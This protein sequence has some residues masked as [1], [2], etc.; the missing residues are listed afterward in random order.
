MATTPNPTVG[1]ASNG[2]LDRPSKG[3]LVALL[4]LGLILRAWLCFHDDGIYWPDEIYQSLE[5][6][7]RLVFGYGLIP[8]EFAEGA[9]NWAFPGLVAAILKVAALVGGD[10]PRHYLIAIRLVFS[11]IGMVTAWGTYRLARSCGAR[12]IGAALGAMFFALAP[13][14]IYFAPRALS[15]TAS[16]AAVVFG[17]A[18]VLRP[19]ARRRDVLVGVSLL[20]FSAL[21]RLQ[22]GI[23]C[24]GILGLLI[25]RRRWRHAAMCTLV[26]AGWAVLYGALDWL[27]WGEWFHSAV[28]YLRFN[29]LEGKAAQWGESENTYYLRVLWTSMPIVAA[30]ATPLALV[31]AVRSPG[32]FGIVLVYL[33]L[34]SLIGHKELRFVLPLLPL[35]FALAGA[36][37]SWVASWVPLDARWP[38][39]VAA[40]CSIVA[41][42]RFH[43]LTFGELGQ[44]EHDRSRA[45]AY[46]DF[47][48]VNRLLLAAHDQADLCG[49]DI[50]AAH[51]AWT[52]GATYLH[53]NVPIFPRGTSM[54]AGYYNYVITFGHPI[55]WG[56]IVA[57]QGALA[58]V[59]LPRSTCVPDPSYRWKLP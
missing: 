38:A 45:S 22:N 29:V 9:R 55:G 16:A 13:P 5:P 8:W 28:A 34:H 37:F 24:V 43:Q 6:A 32:L 36:G 39:M 2:V 12:P 35:W 59:N 41:A 54:S 31:A 30:I 23:F 50:E 18:W 56:R 57:T 17:F 42:T 48:P 47:G 44:Y 46:D 11:A 33:L 7:H 4:G 25:L 58:L 1:R 20:G 21:L 40:V 52:G 15:E 53:R 49:I 10:H 26:L 19:A 3:A 51:L 27:T 14:A